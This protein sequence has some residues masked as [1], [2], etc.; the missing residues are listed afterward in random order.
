MMGLQRNLSV[1]GIVMSDVQNAIWA[2]EM[3]M[4][5]YMSEATM[6]STT[7]GMPMAK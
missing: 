3:P 6:L 5:L 7:K 2:S 1:Q 4:P